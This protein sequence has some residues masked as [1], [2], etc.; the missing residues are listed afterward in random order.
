MKLLIP[1]KIWN[2][3]RSKGVYVISFILKSLYLL[4]YLK[5]YPNVSLYLGRH[6]NI[7]A[8]LRSK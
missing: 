7:A 8:L 6:K 3:E 4:H 1:Y 2:K 5:A